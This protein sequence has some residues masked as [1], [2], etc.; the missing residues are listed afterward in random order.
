MDNQPAK[1]SAKSLNPK[2]FAKRTEMVSVR[3]APGLRYAAEI[4]ARSQRRTVSSLI[5]VAVEA[6]LHTLEVAKPG[7]EQGERP[8]KLMKLMDSLWD[9]D[10]ADRF[11]KLAENHRWLLEN[12]EEHRWK[13]IQEHFGAKGRLTPEQH[14][15]LRLVY[16][17]IKKKVAENLREKELANYASR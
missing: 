7:A 16:D 13:A 15:A 6:Y 11:V 3:L 2:Q 8:V 5:E 4:A 9:P 14:A 17:D 1:R 10:E 12:E